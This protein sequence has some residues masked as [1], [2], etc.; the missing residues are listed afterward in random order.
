MIK[1]LCSLVLVLALLS[2]SAFASE[3][4]SSGSSGESQAKV[5]QDATTFSVTLPSVLPVWVDRDGVVTVAT[6]AGIRNEGF[7][8]V[9]VTD[10]TVTGINDWSLVDFDSGLATAR[11]GDKKFGFELN[12]VAYPVTGVFDVSCFPLIAGKDN[13]DFTYDAVVASQATVVTES[14]ANVVFSVGWYAGG[15]D[16][17]GYEIALVSD[18]PVYEGDPVLMNGQSA[19][20]NA[21]AL[22]SNETAVWSSS[23]EDVITVNATGVMTAVAPGIA[24]ITY[25]MGGMSDTL[26]VRVAEPF[27]V[28]SDNRTEVGYTGTE[29]EE[30]E[31]AQFIEKDGILY[32]VISIGDWAF[33]YCTELASV[34]IPDSVTSIGPGAFSDCRVLSSVNIPDGVTSIEE[35]TFAYCVTLT[36][37]TIPDSVI[38]IGEYAF[39]WCS[40][41]DTII[42]PKSVISIGDW[43]FCA[44]ASLTSL[45]VDSENDAYCSVD[46]VVFSKDMKTLARYPAG[47]D[48]T[49]YV[50]PES[51]T[52]IGAGAFDSSYILTSVTISDSITSI[53]YGAFSGCRALSSVFIPESVIRMGEDLFCGCRALASISVDAK[54]S[55]Y[56]SMDGVV[57]SKGMKTIVA[58]P[59]GKTDTSYV[60]P[61]G[62]TSIGAYAFCGCVSLVSVTIP[63]SVTSIED[64]AFRDS[65]ITDI[66]IPD[67]VTSIGDAAFFC[68]YYLESVTISDSVSNIGESAFSYCGALTDIHYSSTQTQ[69]QV[70]SKGNRWD[71]DTGA[72]TI[73]CTDG[74]LG[75]V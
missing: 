11:V 66:I 26:T 12:D 13:I 71:R 25:T 39:V 51:V 21:I 17:S 70:I 3:L 35:E 48:A 14:I 60:I 8:P 58:Y 10:V 41:L 37:V 22:Y 34:I 42:I 6:N 75:K 62:V 50:I 73:H 57:F 33:Y 43:A 4:T 31:I 5:E 59:V 40:S 15:A 53:G 7:G 49:S 30:L 61:E 38:S 67:G 68:C 65:N 23:D 36:S 69:W 2:T 72:Y 18:L 47:K 52:N 74:D 1:R 63:D 28:T 9:S 64:W 20:L 56:C 19:D 24:D 54:N 32:M 46:G 44:C 55:A 16:I 27:E 45:S 29:D